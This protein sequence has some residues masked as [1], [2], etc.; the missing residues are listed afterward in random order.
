MERNSILLT[1]F[2]DSAQNHHNHY[3]GSSPSA[4]NILALRSDHLRHASWQELLTSPAQGSHI[5]QIYDNDDFVASGVAH[6]AAEGLRRGEAVILTGTEAHLRAVRR[7]LQA[8]DVDYEAALGR[9]QLSLHDVRRNVEAVIRG[10]MPDAARFE[11]MAAAALEKARA[12]GRFSGLRWWG[13]TGNLLLQQGYAKAAL[14]LEDL[15]TAAGLRHGAAML[16]SFL[17]DR[18]DPRGYD[19]L[20]KET[21]CKHSHVIPTDDYVRYRLAVNRAIAEIVGEIKGPLLQSLLS[22]KGLAC[23]L[24]SSQ[25]LLFWIRETLPD[26]FHSVLARVKAYA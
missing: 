6:F 12:G 8:K 15:G 7:E 13:E 20:L 18:F 19:G 16:C 3:T 11:A 14:A 4:A 5:L 25:A 10:G 24:P 21:C 9:G 1:G 22:W 23:D 26:Q 2:H 17:F